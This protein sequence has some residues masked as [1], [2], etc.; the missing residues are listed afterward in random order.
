MPTTV[1]KTSSTWTRTHRFRTNNPPLRRTRRAATVGLSRDGRLARG[2]QGMVA[3]ET[4]F[5]SRCGWQ[6]PAERLT[7][8]GHR[9]GCR[10]PGLLSDPR[11]GG[12]SSFVWRR[13]EPPTKGT[14]GDRPDLGETEAAVEVR[15][16]GYVRYPQPDPESAQLHQ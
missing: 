9:A 1:R 2:R 6:L 4:T 13:L 14:C 7:V 15:C 11:G 12:R 16:L 8:P 3:H 10:T 5:C